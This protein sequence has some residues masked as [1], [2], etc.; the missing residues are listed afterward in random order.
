MGQTRPTGTVKAEFLLRAEQTPFVR[1]AGELRDLTEALEWCDLNSGDPQSEPGAVPVSMGGDHLTRYG[2]DGTPDVSELCAV[3]YA[4]ARQAGVKASQNLMAD[5]LDLR[6][7]FPLVW[8]RAQDL[9]CEVWVL[10]RITVM[11][12]RL[13]KAQ[14]GFVDAAV[15][16]VLE[17]SPCRVLAIVE[18]KVIEADTRAHEDL[19]RQANSR[20]GVWFPRPRAGE[21]LE[22]DGVPGSRRLAARLKPGQ[23]AELEHIIDLIADHLADEYAADPD[24]ELPTGDQLRAEAM[25][26]LADPYAAAAILDQAQADPAVAVVE[27]R[28]GAR[29]PSR[30]AKVHVHVDADVLAGHADGVVRVEDLG[31]M[32]LGQLAELLGRT[33]ITLAPVIDLRHMASVNGY[34]HP[35]AMRTRTELRTLGDVFPHSTHTPGAS[36]VDHDH[37]D[38][39][40]PTGPPG[41]TSDLNDAPLTRRH[42][43]AKTHQGYTL[44][45]TGPGTY[46]WTTPHGIRRTV[47]H[48]GTHLPAKRET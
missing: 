38:A 27:K 1:R 21:Q 25:A 5:A 18:A 23:V 46:E 28:P 48:T 36:A 16:G 9:V 10:R 4:V 17:Q 39:Y 20:R 33:D 29:K 31:P 40:D 13:T 32:L 24:A 12:R 43:R 35:A 19:I 26:V 34:E 30:A 45:Q 6:H 41:Q 2:G 42:H 3:E 15:V 37:P 8:A 14:A 47:D 7:R 44:R 22:I 11:A